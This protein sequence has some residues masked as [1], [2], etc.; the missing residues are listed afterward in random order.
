[1]VG[2]SMNKKITIATPIVAVVLSIVLY[3]IL[4][5]TVGGYVT[6]YDKAY[7]QALNSWWA[8]L[9]FLPITVLSFVLG[10]INK[11]RVT[12]I[13]SVVASVVLIVASL[14]ILGTTKK[15]STS[16]ED[17]I[18]IQEKSNFSFPSESTI[19]KESKSN[20]AK[21]PQDSDVEYISEGAIWFDSSKLEESITESPKWNDEIDSSVEKSIPTFFRSMISSCDKFMC[22][23]GE[24]GRVLVLAYLD[25]RSLVYFSEFTVF[26]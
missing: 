13:I 14:G 4:Y 1:M 7:R 17:L 2:D 24:G 15:Y 11:E 6:A 23:K 16:V 12:I 5:F 10:L 19:I 20:K 18:E 21:H 9:A 25:S 3:A 26:S 8:F 22:V